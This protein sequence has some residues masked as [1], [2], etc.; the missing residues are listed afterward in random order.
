MKFTVV[1]QLLLGER[2]RADGHCAT[3]TFEAL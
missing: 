2:L 1:E 3:G